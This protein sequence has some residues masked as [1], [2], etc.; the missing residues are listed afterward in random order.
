MSDTMILLKGTLK[1]VKYFFPTVLFTVIGLAY[2]GWDEKRT[3]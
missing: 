1:V 3:C 2:I